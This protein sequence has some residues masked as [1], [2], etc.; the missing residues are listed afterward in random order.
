[1]KLGIRNTFM[2]LALLAI[3]F[4]N[5][6]EV[7]AQSEEP[8]YNRTALKLIC[9]EN[10]EGKTQV[11]GSVRVKSARPGLTIDLGT[12]AVLSING[13]VVDSQEML[14][15]A[16]P[17]SAAGQCLGACLPT[18]EACV[19]YDNDG[20]SGCGEVFG[21][22]IFDVA[23]ALGDVVQMDLYATDGS[24]VEIDTSDDSIEKVIG[25]AIARDRIL[26]EIS[27]KPSVIERKGFIVDSFFD[28]DYIIDYREP[29][30]GFGNN[31][32]L[33]L[34]VELFKKEN[35]GKEDIQIE[36]ISMNLSPMAGKGGNAETTWKVEKGEK[37]TFETEILSMELSGFQASFPR[38]PAEPGDEFEVRIRP[39]PHS[40]A[41]PNPR[42]D[43]LTI[44]IPE[45]PQ[46][47]EWN[48]RV[49]HVEFHEAES[50]PGACQVR[51]TI[52][53]VA[54][55]L[56]APIDLGTHVDLFVNNIRVETYFMEFLAIPGSQANHCAD[57]CELTDDDCVEYLNEGFAS[58]G[59]QQARYQFDHL[60]YGGD[61]VRVEVRQ[62]GGSVPEIT[63][64]DDSLSDTVPNKPFA[65]YFVDGL[66]TDGDGILNSEIGLTVENVEESMAIGL[67]IILLANGEPVERQ[68]VGF[69]VN[70]Q[71]V[72]GCNTN[73]AETGDVCVCW[74]G[75]NLCGCGTLKILLPWE[76]DTEPG[77]IMTVVIRPLPG[78][79]PELPGMEED[80]EEEHEVPDPTHER[81]VFRRGDVAF[82]GAVNLTDVIVFLQVLF[83][84]E[85]TIH[86]E[87]AA[88]SDDNG[89]LELTDG[90]KTLTALFLGGSPI[91]APGM[92]ECGV[93]PT[94]DDLGCELYRPCD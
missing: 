43:S 64:F 39:A 67:I 19:S 17:P 91:P 66:D 60:V 9:I 83:L 40:A 36:L 51:T 59:F 90:I 65:N 49:S 81:P 71:A 75:T 27:A 80:N 42:N 55:N 37:A 35:H 86:C 38:V 56:V 53:A 76:Y 41:D 3:F 93:D 21:N 68:E 16:S 10:E 63:T 87:D 31:E 48:R 74:E 22:V 58:C 29:V 4:G 30:S 45:P 18:N 78:A 94:E 61:D 5:T 2:S 79:L 20:L 25:R 23:P 69:L 15:R 73:C 1:M 77:D 57:D 6:V 26:N 72:G 85:G 54:D 62:N 14:F 46:R 12:K 34:I 84:G 82:D 32:N 70:D 24:M 88:D 7:S 52:S 28:I 8:R 33:S 11:L 50:N 89:A 13:Q 44:V 47:P 92:R